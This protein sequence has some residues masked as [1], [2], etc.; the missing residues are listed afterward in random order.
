ML[1]LS[2][3]RMASKSTP[4]LPFHHRYNCL[5]FGLQS[6]QSCCRYQQQLVPP[7]SVPSMQTFE[8]SDTT[9]GDAQQLLVDSE[10]NQCEYYEP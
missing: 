6:I 1:T 7:A 5:R 8:E 4:I 2:S 10:G 9:E 3:R